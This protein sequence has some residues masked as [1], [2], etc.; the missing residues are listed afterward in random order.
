MKATD[1]L[2]STEIYTEICLQIYWILYL[3]YIT[4][5]MKLG[6]INLMLY[7]G[8]T[9]MQNITTMCIISQVP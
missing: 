2:T 7:N 4:D 3:Q 8:D 9:G 1:R 5:I 6:M